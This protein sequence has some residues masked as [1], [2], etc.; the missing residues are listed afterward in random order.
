MSVGNRCIRGI[1]TS[2]SR[3]GLRLVPRVVA[4]L[5]AVNEEGDWA[6]H[7]WRKVLVVHHQAGAGGCAGTIRSYTYRNHPVESEHFERSIR[8]TWC[9]DCRRWSSAI[10]FVPRA[11]NLDDPLDGLDAEKRDRLLGN[12]RVLVQ[13]LDR[14]D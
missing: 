13:Y 6:R 7:R 8:L 2:W 12:E 11:H 3:A 10:V 4:E 9:S 5:A 14:L 1:R